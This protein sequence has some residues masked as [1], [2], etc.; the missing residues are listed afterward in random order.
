MNLKTYL[1][2]LLILL[3]PLL[4]FA[5]GDDHG[6]EH[7]G[8]LFHEEQEV[9]EGIVVNFN[10]SPVPLRTGVPARLDF[11][12]NQKPGNIPV[13]DLEIEHE[14]LMHI[15]GARNDLEEFFHIHPGF[16]QVE[17]SP[18]AG[19]L[20][21]PVKLPSASELQKMQKAY[22][23]RRIN[24]AEQMVQQLKKLGFNP[25]IK[26]GTASISG[27]RD[28]QAISPGHAIWFYVEN[29]QEYKMSWI[30][31]V[32]IGERGIWI[33]SEV[34]RADDQ[35]ISTGQG[36]L[37]ANHVFKKPGLYKLWSEIKKSGVV[38]TF[39]HPEISV[40]G[41]GVKSQ[42]NVNFERNAIVGDYQV[43]LSIPQTVTAGQETS[44]SFDVHTLTGN[45]AMLDKYLGEDMH[46]A[47]IKDDLRQFVHMHPTNMM[48]NGEDHHAIQDVIL[49]ARAHGEVDDGHNAVNTPHGIPFA[50]IFPEPGLYKVFAQFRPAGS[51]LGPDEALTA[52]FWVEVEEGGI[53]Q[54]GIWW[55]LLIAST[56]AM[57][58][59]SFGVNRYI[60]GAKTIKIQAH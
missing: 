26:E 49:E 24:E 15:I 30:Q 17:Q 50:A 58:G 56:V 47:V 38:H 35:Q 6:G 53:T 4:V 7:G 57:V 39:G 25:V 9:K 22:D 28:A 43:A 27:V 21:G 42:K 14:K 34:M 60:E 40:Q 29:G 31:P 44:F 37:S 19:P 5:N 45:E 59:L 11:F 16:A 46:V 48:M 1:I 52:N 33:I 2:L 12:V 51:N 23:D 32:R 41:E 13:V 20:I 36:M 10:F 18:E 3:A 55:V 8:S 54:S